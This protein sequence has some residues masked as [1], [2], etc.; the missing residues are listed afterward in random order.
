VARAIAGRRCNWRPPNAG[1]MWRYVAPAVAFAKSRPRSRRHHALVLRPPSA[2]SSSSRPSSSTLPLTSLRARLPASARHAANTPLLGC[3]NRPEA[4]DTLF[5]AAEPACPPR[6][7][8]HLSIDRQ[9]P[10]PP[11]RL[12]AS[13]SSPLCCP[14]PPLRCPLRWIRTATRTRCRT[15]MAA[16]TATHTAMP[17]RRRTRRTRITSTGTSQ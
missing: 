16:A 5:E 11:Q 12:N 15:C 3:A 7:P 6:R 17:H 2:P 14:C 9:T 1:R 10:A 13:S 4:V 8:L